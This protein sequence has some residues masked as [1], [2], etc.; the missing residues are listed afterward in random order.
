MGGSGVWSLNAQF[1]EHMVIGKE[2]RKVDYF[3]LDC[4]IA[5]VVSIIRIL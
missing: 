3:H 4:G 5:S 1:R 2:V